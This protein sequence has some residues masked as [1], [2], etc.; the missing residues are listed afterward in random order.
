MNTKLKTLAQNFR[1]KEAHN[2]DILQVRQDTAQAID[3][4][5][6]AF[7]PVPDNWIY[8]MVVGGLVLTVLIVVTGSIMKYDPN[9]ENH[10]ALPAALIALGS[11]AL[12][13]LVG[14]L[15]PSPAKVGS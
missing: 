3:E 12:G 4:I 7:S 6:E 11:T 14:L 9:P 10:V 5:A 2:D 15:A 1:E 8:R 13:G